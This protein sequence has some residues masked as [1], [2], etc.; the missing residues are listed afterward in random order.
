MNRFP[1]PLFDIF[2]V[3]SLLFVL[4]GCSAEEDNWKPHVV[5]YLDNLPSDIDGQGTAV[6][7]PNE[8]VQVSSTAN[9]NLTFTVGDSGIA[10]GGFVMLQ[11]SPWWGWSQPQIISPE[12]PGYTVVE[13]SFNDPSLKVYTLPLNRVVVFSKKRNFMSGEKITFIYG[14]DARVDRFA[15]REELFQVFV[16]ADGDGHSAGI[17]NPPTLQIKAEEPT[18]LNVIAPS[19]V[20]PLEPIEIR[21]TPLDKR[22]NWSAFPTGK[23]TLSVIRNGQVSSTLIQ[24]IKDTE[25]TITFKYVPELEGIYFF[26]IEGSKELQ[27]RSNVMDCQKGA[28]KLR[29]YFGDIHGHSRLSDG[30][31]TPEDYYKYAR[32]VSGLD[33]ASLTDHADHG[34]IPIRGNVWSHIQKAANNAYEK[35]HFVTFLGFEWT[36]WE[37]GHRYVYF[38]DGDGPVFRSVDTE[39]DTPQKL[40][41]LLETYEAMTIAHHTGGGPVPIDWNVKPGSKEWLVEISSIHGTSEYYGG[42][43]M[44][45]RPVKGSF[46]RDALMRGYRLGIIGSGDTHDGHPGQRTIGA[47][48]SGIVG[49]YSTGLTREDVWYA[50]K[51]RR[52]YATSGPKIIL[53][54][55]AADSP[56]GS[57]I[58]W[59]ASKGSIPL[60]IRAIG[61]D[62]IVSVE[63]IRNGEQ[64]IK[65][66][67]DG[68]FVHYFLEDSQ[69]QPGTSWYYSRVLQRDGN[70][71]WSS[72]VWITID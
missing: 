6:L 45:Y 69:P 27:G 30:T 18:W 66:K 56:M 51:R 48:V 7:K 4:I 25:K 53:D 29:L 55:R 52:V 11:I 60:D 33:I 14:N 20:A 8:P 12:V 34:T 43:S 22:G 46:V 63:I 50:F 62:E 41:N 13:T 40:W 15:E 16:D 44:I 37:Y 5:P 23:Y 32:T 72:P 10:A 58:T 54:F 9:F 71:A 3:F 35:G 70:M 64:I 26:L 17:V 28:R 2:I 1:K 38:R 61:C 67:A 47:A 24:N 39:S 68:V 36:N 57:E 19:Q 42:E 65:E 49:V 31:G 59:T 21:A